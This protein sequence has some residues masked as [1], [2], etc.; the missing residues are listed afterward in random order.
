MEI[1]GKPMV[2]NTVLLLK[3][4]LVVL[5]LWRLGPSEVKIWFTGV[6]FLGVVVFS[7]CLNWIEWLQ[8]EYALSTPSM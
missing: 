6:W 5:S 2:L 7:M 3:R 4:Q 8:V 1:Y